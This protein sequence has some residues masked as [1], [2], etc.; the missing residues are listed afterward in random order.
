MAKR[1]NRSMK[2]IEPAVTTLSF[3]VPV[4]GK[5]FIDISRA[6]SAVNRRFYRQGLNWAVA[7]MTFTL[8]GSGSGTLTVSKIPQTWVAANA[9]QKT[10]A[11][12]LSQQN[13][14]LKEAGAES[15]IA[16]FRD[17]KIYLDTDMTTATTQ[18]SYNTPVDGDILLPHDG[19]SMIGGIVTTSLITEG[20]WD[21]SEIVVPNAGGV[22]G[23]TVEY[24]LHML[25][26]NN[27][28][29]NSRGIIDGYSNSRA[30]PQSPDP[31][32][33]FLHNNDN[34]F[35]QM[36]DVGADTS[37]I[38]QNATDKNDNLPYDQV[39]Y[40]GGDSNFRGAEVVGYGFLNN[41]ATT[42]AGQ[43]RISGTNFPCGLIRIDSSLDG[44][45]LNL[46]MRLVPGSHRGYLCEPMQDM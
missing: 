35:Q 31:S 33:P 13:E 16:A 37:E 12:W 4:S 30:Y 40:P 22:A 26:D 45:F 41:G 20:E 24:T 9:W 10:Q 39:H 29:G 15:A 43:T 34:F 32:S 5:S 23:N 28:G 18:T 46:T 36:V 42:A 17:F 14:D 2:K 1:K 19:G 27:F 38:I 21:Y 25:G 8:T 11:H 44:G 6:A 7:D 3:S